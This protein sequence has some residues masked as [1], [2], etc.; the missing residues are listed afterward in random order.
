MFRSSEDVM[1]VPVAQRDLLPK[2]LGGLQH[3]AAVAHRQSW[4]RP[5]RTA[6]SQAR[7]CASAAQGHAPKVAPDAPI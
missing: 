1:E 6:V 7:R 3:A 2:A 5:A 4:S